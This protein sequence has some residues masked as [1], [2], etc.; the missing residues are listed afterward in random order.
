M[1]TTVPFNILWAIGQLGKNKP[2]D[3]AAAQVLLNLANKSG[4]PPL[5]VDGKWSPQML[6]ALRTFEIK[7]MRR[8]TVSLSLEPGSTTIR[9]L[10]VAAIPKARIATHLPS[11][12]ASA[13]SDRDY[14]DAAQS[15]G[16]EAAAV[17]AVAAVE[18]AGRGFL[19]SGRPKI[20][21]ESHVFSKITGHVYDPLFPDIST[22]H[23][24]AALY[25]GGEHEYPRLMKA[26]L[27]NR[28]AALKS[29]SWGKFQIIGNFCKEADSPDIESFVS[30]MCQSERAQ[31]DA[32]CAFVRSKKLVGAMKSHD[33]ATFAR[34]YNGPEFW[35]KHYDRRIKEEFEKAERG[36]RAH[37]GKPVAAP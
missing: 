13:I 17:R 24:N 19:P 37:G 8:S 6:E 33:W 30:A 34:G 26:M 36:H 18:S 29:A 9:A 12:K 16:C 10:I 14:E 31:L 11:G 35:K 5:P 1:L 3:V 21:F 32:F 2:T 23:Q 25:K 20:L 22:R 7:Y 15:I 28:T 27:L 4:I